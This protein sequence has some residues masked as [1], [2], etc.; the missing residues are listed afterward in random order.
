MVEAEGL[1]PAETAVDEAPAETVVE[2]SEVSLKAPKR[3]PRPD[4]EALNSQTDSLADE[5][6]RYKNRVAD[7]NVAI[8]KKLEGNRN[9]EQDKNRKAQKNLQKEFETLLVS[10]KSDLL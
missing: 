1:P 10:C 7:I 6:K 3:L 4:R 5:I 9:S 8:K 2:T